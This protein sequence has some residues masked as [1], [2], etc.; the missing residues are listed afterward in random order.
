MVPQSL[1]LFT[2]TIKENLLWGNEGASN[3]EIIR[4]AKIAQA[5]EFISK[6]EKGYDTRVT[7]NGENFSGGQRQ[8]LTIARAIVKNAEILILDDSSSA[9]DFATDAALRKA[10]KDNSE[11]LTVII[12]SQRASAIK[13]SDRIIVFDDGMIVGFDTHKKLL[14]NCEIYRQICSSQISEEEM[15]K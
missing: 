9:L 1:E 3:E 2:G 4:A 5:H 14:N 10:I 11:N 15:M 7:R 13:E 12:V 6:L 8:R